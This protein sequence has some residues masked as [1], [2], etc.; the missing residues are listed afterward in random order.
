MCDITGANVASYW[1]IKEFF[2]KSL[3][4]KIGFRYGLITHS[5]YFNKSDTYRVVKLGEHYRPFD[6]ITSFVKFE[7]FLSKTTR[8]YEMVFNDLYN[9]MN[10]GYYNEKIVFVIGNSTCYDKN[11]TNVNIHRLIS[12]YHKKGIKVYTIQ[13]GVDY[14]VVPFYKELS[15][16]TGG[17]YLYMDIPIGVPYL[18]QKILTPE[19]PI[20]LNIPL[21]GENLRSLEGKYPY[22]GKLIQKK[23]GILEVLKETRVKLLNKTANIFGK[24]YVKKPK[25]VRSKAKV[26]LLK[27]DFTVV[28]SNSIVEE[29]RH[30]PD[31][32]EY[33]EVSGEQLVKEGYVVYEV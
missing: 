26:I 32:T 33:I 9:K 30:D 15:S 11:Y 19:L 4:P 21:L 7:S 31:Y 1:Q 28:S 6:G 17:S 24:M 20:M 2:K 29:K 16:M 8:N 12:D 10:W 25:D 22:Q 27:D 3:F 5:D 23:W 18:I 14:Q 13:T